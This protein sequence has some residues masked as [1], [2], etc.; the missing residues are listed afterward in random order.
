MSSKA[1]AEKRFLAEVSNEKEFFFHTG[2][3]VNNITDFS[4]IVEDLSEEEVARYVNKEKNDFASWVSEVVGDKKLAGQLKKA[5]K[6]PTILKKI[7]D[8]ISYLRHL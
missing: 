4:H 3:H 7:E 5:R 1:F 2:V 8:R 6:K